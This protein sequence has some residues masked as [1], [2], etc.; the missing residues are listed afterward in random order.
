M[1]YHESIKT[2]KRHD[3]VVALGGSV[4]AVFARQ[5]RLGRW[6]RQEVLRRDEYRATS[7][8]GRN[9]IQCFDMRGLDIGFLGLG[10][11]GPSEKWGIGMLVAMWGLVANQLHAPHVISTIHNH[12]VVQG[13]RKRSITSLLI[14]FP[15]FVWS[16]RLPTSLVHI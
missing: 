10:D 13:Y 1:A 3:I 16:R 5:V 4:V 7:K 8:G 2:R 11:L 12:A 14:V 9:S 6:M 15:S